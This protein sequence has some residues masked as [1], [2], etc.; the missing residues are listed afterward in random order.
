MC[1]NLDGRNGLNAPF[2][3]PSTNTAVQVG[4]TLEITWDPRFFNRSSSSSRANVVFI[5]ADFGSTASD[6]SFGG[7]DGFTS[8][9]LD[10]L[11]GSF[12][13]TIL[14]SFLTSGGRETT[15]RGARLFLATQEE[16]VQIVDPGSSLTTPSASVATRITGPRV[17]IRASPSRDN[18]NRMDMPN[19]L[20][21]ALPVG[22]GALVVLIIGVWFCFRRWRNH[23]IDNKNRNSTSRGKMQDLEMK[24]STPK[25]VGG[26]NKPG[27]WK[28]LGPGRPSSGP[29]SG[30]GSKSTADQRTE[31]APPAFRFG[32]GSKKSKAKGQEEIEIVHS[33]HMNA[34]GGVRPAR[35][36]FVG[37]KLTNI[38]GGGPAG[39]TSS[40]NVFR[41]EVRRQEDRGGQ[42]QNWR[43]SD[44]L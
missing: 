24:Q 12:T 25:T 8:A 34:G 15:S 5:Q 18:N 4:R 39:S 27:F 21:I 23:S 22:L 40:N 29:G 35:M 9:P 19:P 11:S 26:Q 16:L 30:Y 13:W 3:S 43:D 6:S 44:Y 14:N 17:V 32:F 1:D 7:R 31:T 20:S 42:S 28:K 38:G 10:P 36:G 41:D 33:T 2:C 37:G